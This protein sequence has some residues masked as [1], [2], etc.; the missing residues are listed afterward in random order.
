MCGLG[1]FCFF[2]KPPIFLDDYQAPT[3]TAH[4]V[5][6]KNFECKAKRTTSEIM[7]VA[8]KLHPVMV[9]CDRFKPGFVVPRSKSKKRKKEGRA[10]FF[11]CTIDS[12]TVQLTLG[13]QLSQKAAI[14]LLEEKRVQQG[15]APRMLVKH[16][17][18]KVLSADRS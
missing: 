5:H 17:Q 4:V 15:H 18:V 3:T 10:K 9:Q 8:R 7:P 16:R 1:G 2:A 14:S 11:I 13:R 6:S 12:A